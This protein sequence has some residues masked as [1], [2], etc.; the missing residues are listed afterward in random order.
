MAPK[1]G[2]QGNRD[3]CSSSRIWEPAE[4]PK[5]CAKLERTVERKGQP[6]VGVPVSDNRSVSNGQFLLVALE[7]SAKCVQ[8]FET[9]P[10]DL[11][12]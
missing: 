7:T 8:R 3:M 6:D 9:S 1:K 11:V 10:S 12:T 4:M 5:T 2:H